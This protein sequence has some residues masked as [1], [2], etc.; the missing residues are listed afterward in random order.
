MNFELLMLNN[1]VRMKNT[2][3]ILA[4]ELE[5]TAMRSYD[6]TN[7]R[8]GTMGQ[9][10]EIVRL[11]AQID[12]CVTFCNAVEKALRILPKPYR[13]LLVTVY[14]KGVDK[15]YL[16]G[17]YGVSRSTVYRKLY[18]ARELFKEALANIGCDEQWFNA[19]YGHYEFACGK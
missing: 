1:A 9:V 5:L 18:K 16:A 2:A 3:N 10:G 11:S 8:D 15:S 12:E 17:K 19:N 13:A 14:F 7:W 6:T 4:K